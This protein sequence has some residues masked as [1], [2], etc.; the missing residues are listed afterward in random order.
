M[1]SALEMMISDEARR[2]RDFFRPFQLNSL[3][4]LQKIKEKPKNEARVLKNFACGALISPEYI[5]NSI[6]RG[7]LIYTKYYISG[8]LGLRPRRNS[9]YRIYTI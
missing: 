8:G 9:I 3:I 1:L 2:R 4:L 6:Y 7:P 5:A